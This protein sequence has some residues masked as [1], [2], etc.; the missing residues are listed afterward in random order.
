MAASSSNRSRVWQYSSSSLG[1]NKG[2][3]EKKSKRRERPALATIGRRWRHAQT[4]RKRNTR[5]RQVGAETPPPQP[6]E[7]AGCCNTRPGH[8][9]HISLCRPPMSRPT[10]AACARAESISTWTGAP[11]ANGPTWNIFWLFLLR[12]RYSSKSLLTKAKK[13]RASIGRPLSTTTKSRTLF[14]RSKV[15]GFLLFFV[16]FVAGRLL[17]RSHVNRA[18]FSLFECRHLIYSPTTS[19]ASATSWIVPSITGVGAGSFLMAA[20]VPP[21]AHC[22]QRLNKMTDLTDVSATSSSHFVSTSAAD[23]YHRPN[24]PSWHYCA[25]IYPPPIRFTDSKT[26]WFPFQTGETNAQ[27]PLGHL[28]LFF[29]SFPPL[30]LHLSLVFF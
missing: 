9:R 15:E 8:D 11:S 13:D 18:R 30:Y 17:F 27:P 28:K 16:F 19:C 24:S 23:V 22:H 12:C 21:A 1:M 6:R 10:I 25:N 4:A 7:G 3:K 14:Y 26:N 2:G 5:T 20:V 29:F